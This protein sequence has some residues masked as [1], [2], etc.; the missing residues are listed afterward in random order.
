MNNPLDDIHPWDELS[1]AHYIKM[2]KSFFRTEIKHTMAADGQ[3]DRSI[4]LCEPKKTEQGKSELYISL[5]ANFG[6]KQAKI[7]QEGL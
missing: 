4:C 3:L 5:Q 2:K 1:L 7:W 6:E